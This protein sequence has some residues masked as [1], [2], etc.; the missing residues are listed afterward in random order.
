MNII[1]I[2]GGSASGKTTIVNEL[3]KV[4]GAENASCILLDNYYFDFVK[5]G[6]NPSEINYDRP[7]SFDLERFISDLSLLKEGKTVDVLLYDFSSHSYPGNVQKLL[8]RSYLLV[9]GLFLF[10]IPSIY[11]FFDLKIFVD[12]P[13]RLRL[14][15]RI[16]RD[17][18]FR[19]RTRDS[20]I[21]QYNKFV[22]PMH[23][24]FVAPNK[25]LADLVVDGGGN[26]PDQ[27][28]IIMK[29]INFK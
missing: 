16:K 5:K 24:E 25:D 1:G 19:G 12:A 15:R 6:I 4:L 23:E 26:I 13:E 28:K 3:Q 27:I 9:D 29:F 11:H 22:K 7:L 14:E 10:N 20:I 18:N 8:P 17:M 2:C 21:N